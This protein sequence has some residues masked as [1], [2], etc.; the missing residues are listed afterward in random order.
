MGAQ[1]KWQ[2]SIFSLVRIALWFLTFYFVSGY[3]R[4]T[5]LRQFQVNREGTQS[6]ICMYPSSPKL[7]SH[8]GCCITLSRVSCAV[9][10]PCL[11]NRQFTYLQ[12]SRRKV[13]FMWNFEGILH[14]SFPHSSFIVGYPDSSS[15]FL[16]TFSFCGHLVPAFSVLL[17]LLPVS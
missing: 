12:I 6:C 2:F 8:P 11:I 4:L 5:M 16:I 13:I 17:S 14:S 9:Q 1:H 10:R 3:S 15:L 7:P